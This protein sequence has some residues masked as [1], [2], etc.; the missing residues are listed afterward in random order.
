MD[1]IKHPDVRPVRF[2]TFKVGSLR[3]LIEKSLKRINFLIEKNRDRES[4][5]F[6]LN[7]RIRRHF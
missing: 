6:V 7:I 3:R 4:I 2:Q 5:L 1:P